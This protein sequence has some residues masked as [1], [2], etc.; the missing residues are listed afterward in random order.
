[1]IVAPWFDGFSIGVGG[2]GGNM[3]VCGHIWKSQLSPMNSSGTQKFTW[4]S[5]T[6]PTY[7]NQPF[8]SIVT[9][10]A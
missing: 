8:P 1:M 5:Q 7:Y 4:I 9:T 6:H 3:G 2:S 10:G